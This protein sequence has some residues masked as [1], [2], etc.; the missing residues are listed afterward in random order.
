M[1]RVGNSP[2]TFLKARYPETTRSHSSG[3]G[4]PIIPKISRKKIPKYP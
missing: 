4:N 2:K 3:T 1:A